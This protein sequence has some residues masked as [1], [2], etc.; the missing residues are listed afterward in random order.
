M[1]TLFDP[2]GPLMTVLIK[3]ADIVVLNLLFLICSI[4]IVTIG[5]SLTAL[6]Y[7]TLKMVEGREG[8]IVKS[9]FQAFRQNFKQST[10]IWLILLPSYL[11]LGADLLFLLRSGNS[12]AGVGIF[13]VM[14]VLFLA[15]FT[16]LFAFPLQARFENSIKNTL[17]NALLLSVANIP[18]TILMFVAT[19]FF[20]ILSLY[21]VYFLPLL[22]LCTFSLP[23]FFH[24]A[25]L[26]KV[27]KKISPE[28]KNLTQDEG[29]FEASENMEKDES[30]KR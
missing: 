22:I 5:A 30:E 10:A 16:G 18:R 9:F 6:Y 20:L 26:Q 12:L 14:V 23:S 11:V 21:S 27:F 3:I 8:Y 4:P 7:V 28:E 25:L 24:A 13:L 2:D 15:I 17:K 19:A 29:I 1:S